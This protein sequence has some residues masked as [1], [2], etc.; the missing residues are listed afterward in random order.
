M[1]CMGIS[2]GASQTVMAQDESLEKVVEAGHQI[3]QSASQSQQLIDT[4]S[5]QVQTKL[6]AFNVVNKEIDGLEVYNNQMQTQLDSQ[7]E[8]LQQIA[9]SMEQVSVIERQISPL[10]A[11]MIDTLETFIQLDVPFLMDERTKRVADLKLMLS[12]ADVSVSEKF[13]RVIEAYQIEADYGRS[14]EAYTGELLL[15]GETKNVDFLRVGRVS[16][17]Y[18]T[19]DGKQLGQWEQ[20]NRQWVELPSNQRLNLAKGFRVA[21]KQI[22]PDLIL[23]PVP[24]PST[25]QDISTQRGGE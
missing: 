9:N 7:M 19:R 1:L 20:S 8:E 6:Q 18:Q 21:K 10:M 11:R 13:R 3:N 2:L 14:I 16:F 17:V 25:A 24:K 15:A 22:A 12:R 4:M 23:V 5:G